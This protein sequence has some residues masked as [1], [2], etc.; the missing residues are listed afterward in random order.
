MII[1]SFGRQLSVNKTRY[2]KKTPIPFK[3]NKKDRLLSGLFPCYPVNNEVI[4][5]LP[6]NM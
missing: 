4:S 3:K 1:A 2:L 5:Y 6:P